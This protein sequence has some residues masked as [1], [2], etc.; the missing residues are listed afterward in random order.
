MATPVMNGEHLLTYIAIASTRDTLKAKDRNTF[1][2]ALVSPAYAGG[3][4]GSGYIEY[5]AYKGRGDGSGTQ[6]GKV[7]LVVNRSVWR[8]EPADDSESDDDE[9]ND[10][11]RIGNI[12]VVGFDWRYRLAFLDRLEDPKGNTFSF[13]LEP[14]WILR[15]ISGPEGG[16]RDFRRAALGSSRSWYAGPIFGFNIR[17]RQVTAS[18]DFPILVFGKKKGDPDARALHS[19][20]PT[21]GMRFDAPFFVF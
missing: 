19:I 3:Q 12:T 16:D 2:N 13:A 7:T 6:G 5:Y 17:L 14:G 15:S 18:M 8:V 20:Q 21:I 4:I 9:F 11:I 1:V 10:D